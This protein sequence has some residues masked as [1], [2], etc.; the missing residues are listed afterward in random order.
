MRKGIKRIEFLDRNDFPG[1]E[2][3]LAAMDFRGED[4]ESLQEHIRARA[5]EEIPLSTISYWLHERARKRQKASE[6][7]DMLFERLDEAK[8]SKL[9]RAEIYAGI[10]ELYKDGERLGLEQSLKFE[11]RWAELELKRDQ[12]EQERAK[13]K[14]AVDRLQRERDEVQKVVASENSGEAERSVV[15]RIR[16][17]YGIAGHDEAAAASGAASAISAGVD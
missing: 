11:L 1:L 3:E 14:V 16:D 7:I 2:K 6:K 8:I 12:L 15:Q 5:G 4:L 17:I 13:L 9:R 10:E